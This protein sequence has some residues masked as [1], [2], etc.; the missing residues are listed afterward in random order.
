MYLVGLLWF[1]PSPIA[2]LTNS[3]QRD[4]Y[5]NIDCGYD[6]NSNFYKK[7]IE[8]LSGIAPSIKSILEI[9]TGIPPF[10]WDLVILLLYLNHS[11]IQTFKYMIE[12]SIL[13]TK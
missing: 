13:C 5:I 10:L 7:P 3:N 12:F 1:I 9:S 2:V 8:I 11:R 6:D 4:G